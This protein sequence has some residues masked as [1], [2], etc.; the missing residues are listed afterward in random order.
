VAPEHPNSCVICGSDKTL[1]VAVIDEQGVP[2]GQKGHEIY[3]FNALLSKCQNCGKGQVKT[4]EH[5]CFNLDEVWEV[6]HSYVLDPPSMDR[7][8]ELL[9]DCPNPLSPSCTCPIHNA[10]RATCSALLRAT[11]DTK[12][13]DRERIYYVSLEVQ[14]GLP[15][16]SLKTE[17]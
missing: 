5:D 8:K 9:E 14:G 16:L 13:E 12:N 3:Y 2:P 11:W 17:Q 15:K 4:R 1:L 10:L 7:L 6:Y